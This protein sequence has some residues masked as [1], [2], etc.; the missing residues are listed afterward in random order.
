MNNASIT[1]M[2]GAA[3]VFEFVGG[4]LLA[5]GLLTRPAAFL[6]SGMAAVGYFYV[7]APRD[8]FPILNG[9][10]LA[11]VYC[12]LLLY[13]SFAGPGAWSVDT[14]L[15]KTEW[16]HRGHADWRHAHVRPD[17]HRSRG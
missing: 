4:L 6:L 3:G 17:S 8:F 2:S 14:W 15:G 13:I 12:F 10:E 7:H 16:R 5:I 1:T 11:I 9:G